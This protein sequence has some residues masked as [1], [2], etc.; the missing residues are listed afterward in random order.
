MT[1]TV[2]QQ[3]ALRG[4]SW[5]SDRDPWQRATH[6]HPSLSTSTSASQG[7]RTFLPTRLPRPQGEA[8]TT[9]RDTLRDTLARWWDAG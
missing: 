5:Y 4:G 3:V 7:F 9:L 6:P 2:D 1:T 8:P